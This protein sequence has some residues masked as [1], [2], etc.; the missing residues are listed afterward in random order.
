MSVGDYHALA[1]AHLQAGRPMDAAAAARAALGLAPDDAA[2]LHLLGVI[3]AQTG[4]LDEALDWLD[5]AVA[6]TGAVAMHHNSRGAV[7]YALDR[8]DEAERS[9][10]QAIALDSGEAVAHCNLGNTLH[11]LARPEEA[12]AS[13]RRALALRPDYAEAASGLGIALRQQGR[14]DEAEAALRAAAA[15]APADPEAA[16]RLGEVLFDLDRLEEAKAC[17]RR[18]LDLDPAAVPACMAL[19]M[20]LQA[21]GDGEGAIAVLEQGLARTPGE[22]RLG[23]ARRLLYSG[24][25][26]GWHLPM[27]ND[28]ERND[29]YDRALR[30]VMTP[31]A[32]VL[33]IGTGSGLVAMMAARA[34]AGHVVTC[35]I[36]VPLARI[37]AETVARNGLAERITVVPKKSTRLRVGVDL[38]RRADVFVS[39]LVNIGLLA[40]D[41]LAIL[42]HARH[43][44][45]TPEARIVPAAAT[46]YGMLIEC[47]DLARINPVRTVSGFDLGAFDVFRSPG[48]A[49][50][51]LAA[52]PHRRLSADVRVLDFDFRCD[53][54]ESGG[55]LLTIEAIADGECHGL[56]FWFDL[57]MVDDP[58]DPIVYSS[59]SR[60]RS[61]HWKQAMH[62]F[63]PPLPLRPGDRLALRALYDPTRISFEV[64]KTESAGSA[65]GGGWG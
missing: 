38:P 55:R 41:M 65:Q 9:L 12:E 28:D 48:Y 61:N 13:F 19:A 50:I 2:T 46:V 30:R 25:V 47:N 27:I 39:E 40:P 43:A 56:A 22:P 6:G 17:F 62:F 49:Q 8:L 34:G 18:A 31:G 45:L 64:A 54:P 26:P 5:R 36:N 51:D 60:K 16:H 32:M 35:E 24:L 57:V 37:A 42:R 29:A 1:H 10:R 59:A 63:N 53:M 7:A 14:F 15:L 11:R 3:A 52:D 20:V 58:A 23:F 44:L 33:E 21:E 4:R